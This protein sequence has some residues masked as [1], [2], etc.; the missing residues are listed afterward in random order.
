[1]KQKGYSKQR[2]YFSKHLLGPQSME[3][4]WERKLR[5][6]GAAPLAG[7]VS[8]STFKMASN[9]WTAQSKVGAFLKFCI[10]QENVLMHP[11]I[12]YSKNT[13]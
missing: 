13:D 5:T 10:N 1:M 6:L 11:L 4:R 12:T 7:D 3:V 8:V 2:I 9:W